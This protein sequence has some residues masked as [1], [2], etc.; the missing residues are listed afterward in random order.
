VGETK[1]GGKK[2]ETFH[3]KGHEG[4]AQRAQRKR[5]GEGEKGRGGDEKIQNLT[6]DIRNYII[7]VNPPDPRHPRA[8][9]DFEN[10]KFGK[11]LH[12]VSHRTSEFHREKSSERRARS[13]PSTPLR[14]QPCI[15]RVTLC[16]SVVK[17]SASCGYRILLGNN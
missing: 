2:F 12:R 13:H 11:R 15:N 10:L 1:T 16:N 9:S 17:S 4:K 14:D 8:I 3:H 7:R 5:R 6:S